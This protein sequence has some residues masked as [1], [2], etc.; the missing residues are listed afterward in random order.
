[1]TRDQRTRRGRRERPGRM[2]V[3]RRATFSL[4]VLAILLAASVAA[5][6]AGVDRHPHQAGVG[7]GLCSSVSAG[8][9]TCEPSKTADMPATARR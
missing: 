3:A 4:V 2:F 6:L 5:V 8:S 1:V 9:P 7:S